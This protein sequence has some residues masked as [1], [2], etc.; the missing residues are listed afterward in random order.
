[1]P[2]SDKRIWTVGHSNR[3][4]EA[5][6]DLLEEA[7]IEQLADIRRFPGSRRQPH[8]S[9]DALRDA[10]GARG[11]AYE[12]LP[13]LGGRRGTPAPDSPNTGWR[14]ASF[15]AYADHMAT[16]AFERGL[17]RLEAI[18]AERRTAMMCSE[19]VPWRCHRRLV[20]DALV[21]RGWE[22]L[23]VMAPGRATPHALT[24]FACVHDGALT[25][26]GPEPGAPDG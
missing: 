24:D 3:E 16:G 2:P 12:H 17:A 18:A 26:P 1:V 11:I 23:D 6:L 14:V 9:G 13:D 25:Y 19:A 22:V 7:G 4:P 10:L 8:F 5:F 21:V 20:A 15:G